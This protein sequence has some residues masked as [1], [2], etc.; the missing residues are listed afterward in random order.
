MI[1]S[2]LHCAPLRLRAPV[3]SRLPIIHS[4]D[5]ILVMM[6]N[7]MLDRLAVNTLLKFVI[8]TL[9]TA[10]VIVLSLGAWDSWGRLA[11]VNRIAAVADASGYLFT[12]LHN[13][14]VDRASTFRDLS[15]DKQFTSLPA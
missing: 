8:A 9:A 10:V 2:R 7:T 4:N 15:A 5:Q 13:L 3:T 14:R 6:G 11:A 12:A 1:R